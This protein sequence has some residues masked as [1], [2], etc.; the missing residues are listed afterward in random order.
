MES[1]VVRWS[2]RWLVVEC[3]VVGWSVRWLGEVR[4]GWLECEVVGCGVRGGWLWG[5][6]WLVVEQ[7]IFSS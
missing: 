5:A 1:E 3:E 6:R 7:R 4:G 2:V